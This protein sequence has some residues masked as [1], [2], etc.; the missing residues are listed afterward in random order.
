M[1]RVST[2]EKPYDHIK[3]VY[4]K[5]PTGVGFFCPEFKQK[6]I[7]YFAL[8]QLRPAETEAVY[9]CNPGAK[10]GSIFVEEDF[11]YYEAPM[12]LQMGRNDPIVRAFIEEKGGIV[13]QGWD[14]AM[15]AQS[16]ADHSAGVTVLLV[17]CEEFHREK[18][19]LIIGTCDQHYDVYIL[20][21]YRAKLEIGDLALAIKEQA[22]KWNPEKIVIEKKQSGTSVM[23][24]LA[25][26]GLPIEGVIVQDNKRDRAVN[27]G[28]G[29]G[30]V[31]GWFK[32]GRVL[33]P[34]LGGMLEPEWLPIYYRELKDFTGEKGGMDDQVDATVHV[35]SHAIREGSAGVRFLEGWNTPEEAEKQMQ[36]P[37]LWQNIFGVMAGIMDPETLVADGTIADPF[38]DMCG[39]CKFFKVKEKLTC[40]RHKIVVTSI[41][42][43][44]ELFDDGTMAS[45]FPRF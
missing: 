35:V 20:D 22:I 44:C 10:I 45:T 7:D 2:P 33:F 39:R 29:A 41:N 24:A 27:G 9:Q 13:A 15:S 40:T 31:Q 14:T 6:R 25:N 17:P 26:S 8:K 11:R 28:A 34:L 4:G 1:P 30:S 23:Q 38:A 36:Q 43:A 32:S 42:P 37:M 19:A 18:E 5:D 3:G 16:S 12:N 21:V